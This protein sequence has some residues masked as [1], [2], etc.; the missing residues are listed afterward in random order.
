MVYGSKLPVLKTSWSR[1]TMVN[2]ATA[3]APCPKDM[4]GSNLFPNDLKDSA[5][6][7]GRLFE[8]VC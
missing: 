3:K 4:S 6:Q 7:M 8:I 5:W 2:I 1:Q